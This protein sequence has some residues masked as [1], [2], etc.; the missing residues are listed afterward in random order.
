MLHKDSYNTPLHGDKLVLVPPDHMLP[1]STRKWLLQKS[2]TLSRASTHFLIATYSRNGFSRGYAIAKK[3]LTTC[4][5]STSHETP[6]QGRISPAQMGDVLWKNWMPK[7]NSYKSWT[8]RWHS[9]YTSWKPP[10][11]WKAVGPELFLQH[12]VQRLKAQ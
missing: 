4:T 10:P 9:I 6:S 7:S 1:N 8:W 2:P 11:G 5:F 12:E 3:N